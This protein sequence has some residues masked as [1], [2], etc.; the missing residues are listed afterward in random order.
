MDTF[1]V[2]KRYTTSLSMDRPL[3]KIAHSRAS[4]PQHFN[5]YVNHKLICK[6]Y[7]LIYM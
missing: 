4:V 3:V 5:L 2:T 6:S 7:I 1:R